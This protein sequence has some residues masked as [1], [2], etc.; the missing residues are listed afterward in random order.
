MRTLLRLKARPAWLYTLPLAL[1]LAACGGG[2]D[3]GPVDN[4]VTPTPP[5]D[6]FVAG[7]EVPQSATTS[8]DGAI[9]FIRSVI[10][11]MS[12]TAEGLALGNAALATSETADP[13]PL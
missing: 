5:P 4:V 1:A 7:S 3:G 9:A 12:E 10:A 13:Q 6:P 2:G 11:S 8:V